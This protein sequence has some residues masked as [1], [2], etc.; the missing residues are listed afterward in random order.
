MK[1]FAGL[2]L[3]VLVLGGI[4]G[5][6]LAQNALLINGAGASFPNPIYSKWISE[7]TK[8]SAGVQINYQ[9]VGS[10]A[11]IKQVTDGTVDFGASDGPMNDD[12]LK[13]YQDKHGFP[14]LHFPTV[15]GAAVPTYNIPGVTATLNF[16][17][18][19]LAG[20]FLGKITMW[21]DPAIAS[22]NKGVN[23]PAKGI[24]VVHRSDGSG[25]TYI[26]TDYL[27]KV[28]EEWKSKVG[29]GTSVNWP[30]G[31][32]GKNS[33]G[34]TAQIKNAPNSIGYVELIYAS[35]N[36]VPYGTVKNSSGDFIKADLASVSAAAAGAAKNMPDDFRVSIT[37]AP[38]K[39]AYPISSFTWLLVPSKFSSSDANKRDAIKGFL[40]WALTDGQGYTEALAYAKLPKP[41][42]DK[43]LKAINNIQ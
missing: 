30:V 43:E 16:T 37:N 6:V 7:Y 1:K 18:E 23:L 33:E 3:V 17:P 29:S 26:W 13:A 41:V 31:L 20:I 19:A 42:V 15:L 35:S 34:V 22:A 25:T 9:S 32:G 24:T 36:N 38:G 11:G 28:S 27:S 10:G 2:L 40:N 4:T 12:Q 8:K 21:N 14:I 39:T 5:V